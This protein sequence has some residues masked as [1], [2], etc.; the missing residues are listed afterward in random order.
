[1]FTLGVNP[2]ELLLWSRNKKLNKVVALVDRIL[3]NPDDVDFTSRS[4]Q[5]KSYLSDFENGYGRVK[6]I[7]E[8][9]ST[10]QV[11]NIFEIYFLTQEEKK[12][13]LEKNILDGKWRKGVLLL[14][15]KY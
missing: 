3:R 13:L 7:N 12:V 6:E 5:M 2:I 9:E 4:F 10:S 15:R 14:R 8:E 11:Q 1:M